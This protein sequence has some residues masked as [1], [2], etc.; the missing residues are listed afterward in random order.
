MAESEPRLPVFET[1]TVETAMSRFPRTRADLPRSLPGVAVPSAS[2]LIPGHRLDRYELLCPIAQGGMAAVWVA[3]IQGV[4]GF[5]KLVVVKTILAEYAM[6]PRY[7]AMF[8]DEARLVANIHHH[9][10]AEILD[11][12]S[13]D[14]VLYLVL[15][16]VEGDSLA[17]LERAASRNKRPIPVPVGLRIVAQMCAG[18]SAAHELRDRAGRPLRVV[19]RDVSPENVLV[20]V[21]GEVKLIDFGIAK[22]IDQLSPDTNT[23]VIKGKIFFMSPEHALGQPLDAR[24]DIWSAGVV[25]YQLLSGELPFCGKSPLETLHI[26]GACKRAP[27]IP[28]LPVVLQKLLD[29]I[30]EPRREKRIASA[31]E[32][33]SELERI[34]SQLGVAT[35]R[36]LAAVVQE[37]LGS[38]VATRR[39]TIETA[40]AAADDRQKL[41][42]VFDA[43][44]EQARLGDDSNEAL[45]NQRTVREIVDFG[46]PTPRIIPALKLVASP[47]PSVPP[48]PTA[49]LVQA[50]PSLPSRSTAAPVKLESPHGRTEDVTLPQPTSHESLATTRAHGW[51]TF[52]IWGASALVVAGAVAALS[53][54]GQLAPVVAHESRA[55]VVAASTVARLPSTATA[56]SALGAVSSEPPSP[57]AIQATD[58]PL[59]SPRSGHSAAPSKSRVLEMP[60]RQLKRPAQPLA[61]AQAQPPAQPA[62]APAPSPAPS[63][64]RD[65]WDAFSEHR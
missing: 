52:T 15:E 8:L 29:R 16:W 44:I 40:L 62:P 17:L 25:L 36:D 4:H 21:T 32:L 1:T 43:A 45:A 41:A 28:G 26:I 61:T 63:P 9:N 33:E 14:S 53:R 38:R 37:H 54:R 35:T 7:E 39:A 27:P 55:P 49:P 65:V 3:R 56:A 5:E 10:V 2:R 46:N 11:L 48:P 13:D 60:R 58:L 22:A 51:R 23:G 6:D 42:Q 30:L 50:L 19:H 20:S 59:A 24:A 57:P 12:G 18:L 31:A 47:E 64:K 34:A